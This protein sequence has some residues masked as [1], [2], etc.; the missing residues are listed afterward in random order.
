MD[1]VIINAQLYNSL[2]NISPPSIDLHGVSV[3]LLNVSCRD[4]HNTLYFTTQ[5]YARW[6]YIP[7]DFHAYNTGMVIAWTDGQGCDGYA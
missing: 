6:T 7:G 2:W 3:M 1:K 4:N 5:S